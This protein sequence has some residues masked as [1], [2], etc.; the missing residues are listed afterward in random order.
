[1][2]EIVFID[3]ERRS[4]DHYR[5]EGQ[6]WVLLAPDALLDLQ[7]VG[8]VIASADVFAS[9]ERRGTRVKF[10]ART[11]LVA[12]RTRGLRLRGPR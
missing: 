5:R 6:R 11:G 1:M 8:T 2:Q 3:V 9:Q 10:A 12:A 4:V 7:C